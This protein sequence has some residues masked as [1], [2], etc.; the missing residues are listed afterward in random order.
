MYKLKD[1][2]KEQREKLDEEEETIDEI[3]DM[4]TNEDD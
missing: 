3:K 1:L 4:V 2:I